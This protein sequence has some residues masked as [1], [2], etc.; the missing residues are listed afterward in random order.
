MNEINEKIEGYQKIAKAY[1]GKPNLTEKEKDELEN[2]FYGLYDIKE[3]G[4]SAEIKELRSK[5]LEQIALK[6][7]L[8]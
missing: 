7:G 3:K 8:V 2:V 5:T 6:R 4:L 1:L